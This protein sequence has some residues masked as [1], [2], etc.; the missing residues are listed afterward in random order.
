MQS[1][2]TTTIGGSGNSEFNVEV[3]TS[4]N[5]TIGNRMGG[6]DLTKNHVQDI[7]TEHDNNCVIEFVADG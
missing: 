1:R 2:S 7:K 4:Y 3:F 6:I 5:L